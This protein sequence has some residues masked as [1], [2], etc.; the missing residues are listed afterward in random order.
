MSVGRPPQQIATFEAWARVMQGI[1]ETRSTHEKIE[2]CSS[3]LRSLNTTD[4]GLA[5]QFMAEG[6]FSNISGKRAS[7]GARTIATEAA[8]FCEIDYDIV[9]KAC[10]TATGS[11]SETIQKLFENLPTARE[12]WHPR[13][14]TL[15]QIQDHCETLAKT[16]DR[17]KKQQYLSYIWSG[18]SPLATKYF[19]RL[20]S[21]GSLRIGFELRSVLQALSLACEV[22]N[23]L[24]RY[25]QMLTGSISK[26][27]VM[28]KEKR[29]S[30]AKFQLFHPMAFMLAAPFSSDKRIEWNEYLAEEKFDGMRC[31]L[32]ANQERVE[33]F[34]RDLNPISE[35]FP[36]IVLEFAK[37]GLSNVVLDGEICVFKN[38]TIQAFQDLQKRMGV[39]KPSTKLQDRYPTVFIAYDLLVF[40]NNMWVKKRMDQRR[41][42]LERLSKVFSIPISTQ[43][44]LS[45]KEIMEHL[46]QQAK[47]HGNEGL[48]LKKRSAAYSFGERKQHWLKVKEPSGTLDTVLLYAHSG[49][50]KRGGTY[51]DFT[52]GVSVK[53]DERYEEEFIPIGKAYGGYSDKEWKELNSQIKSLIIDRFGPTA[54]LKPAIVVELEFE[55]IQPNSRTKAKYTLRFPRFKA[56]RWDLSTSD[57]DTLKEVERQYEQEAQR[58]RTPQKSSHSFFIPN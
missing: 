2:L 26:T 22:D 47:S 10:R 51:S 16:R 6:A 18:L 3:Y 38:D 36:E 19:L 31:Q 46:F 50:G 53:D 7:V 41:A 49:S 29:L 12:K 40:E 9:F 17:V 1:A 39:K 45:S 32:H 33:L 21:R 56:I 48:M 24:I 55:A 13:N 11:S 25:T 52:L 57:V 4:L 42:Q 15:S 28:A 37:K 5:T 23:E 27:A 20:L 43:H 35:Q 58:E 34:S 44:S 8:H 14:W 30:E 54:Q